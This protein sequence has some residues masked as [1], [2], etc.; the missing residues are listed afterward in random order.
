[1]TLPPAVAEKW[2]WQLRARCRSMPVAMFFP[3]HNASRYTKIITEQSAKAVCA[4]CP[5]RVACLDHAI[6]AREPYGVWGGLSAKERLT[7]TTTS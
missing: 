6:E 5:V 7:F 2:D 3:A 4:Q 1:M